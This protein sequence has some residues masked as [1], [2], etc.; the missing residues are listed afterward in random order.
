MPKLEF[1]SFAGTPSQF[2]RFMSI[3]KQVIEPAIPDATLRLTHLLCHTTGEAHDS[4]TSVDPADPECYNRACDILKKNYGSKYVV[5]NTVVNSLKNGP[6][7]TTPKAIRCLANELLNAEVCLKREGMF[8]ELDNQGCIVSVCQRLPKDLRS[9][10]AS[11]TT[12]N[13]RHS[14]EYLTFSDFVKFVDQE[15]DRLNDPIF[16]KESFETGSSL[17]D[18]TGKKTSTSLVTSTQQTDGSDT[19]RR[20]IITCVVCSNNHKLYY[21][22][23]CRKI[24]ED[25]GMKLVS[26]HNL[27]INCLFPNHSVDACRKPY[28]CNVNN[29]KEKYCQYLH[30]HFVK[31]VQSGNTIVN[32]DIDLASSHIMLPIVPIIVN[33]CYA[34]YALLDT[35]SS[36]SFCSKRLVSALRIQG[37]ETTY[38][39]MTLDNA[40]KKS[41]MEVDISLQPRDQSES[42][43][44]R[45]VLVTESIP[46]R[47][48]DVDLSKYNHLSDMSYPASATVD[49][50]IGQNYSDLLFIQEYRRGNPGEPYA[51]RTPLGWCF[52]G[53]TDPAT[54]S[55]S[56]TSYL[57]S[58]KVIEHKLDL[59]QA[60]VAYVTMALY[61]RRK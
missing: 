39:L 18:G 27:C 7:A 16:G 23:D 41:T 25:N 30:D 26:K 55:D 22:D 56:V 51:A 45:K 11:R 42:F 44:L 34:T 49:V 8:G 40:E 32:L 21:C 15:A 9:K 53:P 29:C 50:F 17:P 24:S 47:T 43:Q 57:I 20:R 59:Y 35:G 38:D 48:A 60:E 37:K 52:H 14:S 36:H 2:H 12:R 6:V 13:Q 33:N 28:L 54:S 58:S 4:I 1:E 10:W 5:C 46:V 3:F 31:F 61:T 19:P